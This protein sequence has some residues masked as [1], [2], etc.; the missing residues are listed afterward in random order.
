MA[1]VVA[2]VSA[3]LTSS[4]RQILIIKNS[5]FPQKMSALASNDV[6]ALKFF[7][8]PLKHSKSLFKW[9]NTRDGA[10]QEIVLYV[11]SNTNK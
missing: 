11:F 7:E 8:C 5:L 2:V 3:K 1:A 4:Y 10:E 9:T 6:T